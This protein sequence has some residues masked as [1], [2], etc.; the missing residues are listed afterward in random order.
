[1]DLAPESFEHGM[2]HGARG[3]AGIDGAGHNLPAFPFG[4]R[5]K[6]IHLRGIAAAVQNLLATM[7]HKAVQPRDFPGKGMG[8][9]KNSGKKNACHVTTPDKL[10]VVF[11]ATAS[12]GALHHWRPLILRSPC[13]R[14]GLIC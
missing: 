7:D 2:I 9:V 6:T 1:L 5:K 8:F 12:A 14:R 3:A 11:G 10:S 4:H 13:S